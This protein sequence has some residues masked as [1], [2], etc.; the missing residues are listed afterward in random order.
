M[1]FDPGMESAN[2]Y[3]AIGFSTVVAIDASAHNSAVN[4]GLNATDC[5]LAG[6]ATA[7]GIAVTSPPNASWFGA[8]KGIG[9]AVASGITFIP[10][11]NHGTQA[12]SATM[13]FTIGA[14]GVIDAGYTTAGTSSTLTLDHNK[15][16]RMVTNGY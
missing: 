6:T 11:S 10:S 8:G 16:F 12:T 7:G 14:G 5:V 15:V 13:T 9:S 1:G 3:Y 2:R 4:S